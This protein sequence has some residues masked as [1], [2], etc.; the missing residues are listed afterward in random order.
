[1]ETLRNAVLDLGVCLALVGL[2]TP[3]A[4]QTT[5]KGEVSGGY[6]FL[7]LSSGGEGE[8]FA[9]GWYVDVTGNL[10]ETLGIVFEGGGD[11][12]SVTE[13]LTVFGVSATA[14]ADFKLHEFMGGVRIASRKNPTIVPFGQVLVGGIDGSASF[15]GTATVGGT[16]VFSASG[17]E[18]ATNFALFRA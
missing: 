10:N 16:T 18:S 9:K 11:Y 6:Q 5:P 17:A 8:S 2:A 4:A 13:S 15:S 3:V 7:N 1:M 14:T 12:R